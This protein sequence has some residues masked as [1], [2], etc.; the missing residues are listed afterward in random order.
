MR[1]LSNAARAA[2]FAQETS[3]AF[4]VLLTITHPSFSEDIR[5]SSDPTQELP[6][7]GGRGTISNGL[8][9]IYCPF[10]ITLPN[11][12]DTGVA[13]AQISVDNVDR[14]LTQAIRQADSAV[15]IKIEIVLAS[16]PDNIE[17]SL[18]GFQMAQATY[19]ALTVSGE[20]SMEYYDLEPF[21]AGRFN[22][23]GFPGIF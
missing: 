9:Y 16:A 18:D 19:D 3:E 15:G 12:D 1:N 2:V 22:P 23:S 8:E 14:R 6:E 13:R 11:E 10:S 7:A 20:L 4:L 5:V 17:M 21:P